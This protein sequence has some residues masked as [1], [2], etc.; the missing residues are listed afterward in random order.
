MRQESAQAVALQALAFLAAD[1][2]LFGAFLAMAGTDARSVAARA[3]DPD[4]LVS[5]LDFILAED[6]RVLACAQAQGG[7]PEDILRARALLAGGEMPHW[8]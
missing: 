6:A 2:E 7:R 4:L 5:V 3:E 1:D 8:T